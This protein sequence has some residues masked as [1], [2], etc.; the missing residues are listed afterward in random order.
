MLME[1]HVKLHSKTTGGLF[2]NKKE[3]KFL[4]SLHPSFLKPEMNC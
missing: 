2:E 3:K 4:H 1:I